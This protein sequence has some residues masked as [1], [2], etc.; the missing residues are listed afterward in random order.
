[1]SLSEQPQLLS[2]EQLV[3]KFG[4][5]QEFRREL[6]RFASFAVGFSFISITTG[7]FTT[8]G[9]VLNWGGPRGIWTWPLVIVGQLL[10]ALVFGALASR[11]PLAGYSYQWASRLIN[12][13]IGWLTG[14]IS[15][16]FL[17]VDVVAVDYAVAQT[18][19]PTLFGYTETAVNAWIATAAVILIQTLL[20]LFSTV[21]ATR[22]NNTAVGTEV[23]G[24][25]G[26]TLLLLIVGGVRGLLHPDHLFSTGNVPA[27]NYFSLG[28][29][30][31]SGP[32]MLSFLLGAFTIVGFEA[33]ANLAEETHEAHRTVPFAMWS[34]VLL[35]GVVGFAFLIALNLASD[36]LQA[37]AGSAT[38]VADII[39]HVLGPIVGDIFLVLVT[40][41]IF[42]CGLVIFITLTRLIWAMSRDERFP[43][44][45]WLRQVNPNT[46][47]PVPSTVLSFV[48]CE[49]VL[50]LFAGIGL[51][52]NQTTTLSNLFSAAT[53]LPAIIYLLTVIYYMV[54]RRRLPA[55]PGGLNLGVFEWPV[56]VL[57]LVWLV[58]ELLI[59]RDA[60]F[61]VPWLYTLGMFALG[62]IYFVWLLIARPEVLKTVPIEETVRALGNSSASA[63][64]SGSSTT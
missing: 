7:I 51:A 48:L 63:E 9:S 4:Y 24:I 45:H 1:M 53:L 40:F 15:F 25:V 19:L 12:P 2:E 5:R 3:E 56:V 6:K 42:A 39:T 31:S 35:S 16:T 8:Y 54:A 36:N 58:F 57:A 22:I 52:L 28:G 13:K 20:V 60:Q 37:L 34:S 55:I 44:S 27:T 10:V 23:I 59:F 38:P 29:L 14:W 49:L 33:A 30:F 47:T 32:F 61:A 18:V 26:L 50:A 41:S 21:W 11:I 17:V 64:I 46:G 62:L 43:A